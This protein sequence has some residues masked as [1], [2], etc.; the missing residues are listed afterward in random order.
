MTPESTPRT[1]LIIGATGSFGAHAAWALIK[2]GWRIRALARDPAAAA[3]RLGPRSPIEWV[4]GDAMDEA[5]V[6]AAAA[7]AQLVVHAA[8]PPGYRNW[9]GTVLPMA[10]SAMAAAKAADARLVIPGNVYNFAPDAGPSIAEDAPQAPATRKGAIRVEMER[11]LKAASQAGLKVLILRAGDFFGPEAPNSALGWLAT[12][13]RGRLTGAYIPGRAGH[14]FAY[15][16][17]LAETMA[18]LA[19][20]E[21]RLA[22]FEV[23]HFRGQWLERAA[24]FG[25]AMRRASGRP[26]LPLR[27]FPWMVVRLAAP[28][29]E[30]FRELLEMRYL[31]DRPIGLDNARLVRFLGEEP[32]T[33]LDRA[34]RATLADVG[35]LEAPAYVGAEACRSS[36]MMAPTR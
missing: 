13:R 1:A 8:N 28:F 32:H 36:S 6:V 25:E 17:D 30:T 26:D 34:L 23:F 5:S 11:R 35:C 16:P 12:R 20:A 15:M 18:R 33:P 4:K 14:A 9:K 21:D 29:N 24:D 31:W 10:E 22:A 19:D 3:A 2:R 27:P 7:G